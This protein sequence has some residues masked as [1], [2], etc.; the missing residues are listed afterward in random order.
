MRR[1]LPESDGVHA[2]MTPMIDV[3]FLLIIFFMLVAQL[4]R[5]RTLELDLPSFDQRQSIPITSDSQLVIN[6]APDDDL[7]PWRIAHL[8]FSD[9]AQGRRRLAEVLQHARRRQPDLQ[10]LIRADR[11]EHYDRVHPLM[12]AVAEAGVTEVGLVTI[13]PER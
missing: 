1:P 10:V 5:E 11:V 3:V 9:N 2:N 7:T 12:E 6:V 13:P 4:S 8:A